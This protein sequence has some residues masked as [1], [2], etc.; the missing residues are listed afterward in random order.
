MQAG[1]N[2]AAGR[3][4]KQQCSGTQEETHRLKAEIVSTFPCLKV[5]VGTWI[6]FKIMLSLLSLAGAYV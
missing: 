4:G 3:D 1:G 2:G 5:K 6:V